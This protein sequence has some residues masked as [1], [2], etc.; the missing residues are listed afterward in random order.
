MLALKT[1]GKPVLGFITGVSLGAVSIL[2]MN[3][4]VYNE[5]ESRLYGPVRTELEQGA[6][7]SDDFQ[8]ITKS[9]A[10]STSEFVRTVKP[11]A[12]KKVSVKKLFIEDEDYST[13][14]DHYFSYLRRRKQMQEEN[15]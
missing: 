6:T 4:I 8:R 5:F 10:S 13:P 12:M 3:D 1:I 11:F 9:A 7:T 14:E 15:K 2:A